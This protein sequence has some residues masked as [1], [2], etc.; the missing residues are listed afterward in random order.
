MIGSNGAVVGLRGI[1]QD[2]TV[3]GA[4]GADSLRSDNR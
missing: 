2:V 1:G 3:S 4:S